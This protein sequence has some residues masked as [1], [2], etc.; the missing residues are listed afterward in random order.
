MFHHIRGVDQSTGAERE[1]SVHAPTEAEAWVLA[2][3]HGIIPR[4]SYVPP[5][6]SS[7][8]DGSSVE[9]RV[10]EGISVLIGSLLVA[11]GLMGIF[12]S[13]AMDTSINIGDRTTPAKVENLGMLHRQSNY[14]NLSIAATAIGVFLVVPRR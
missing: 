11:G 13:L 6:R 8:S 12:G 9:D 10:S 2:G 14:L 7:A 1:L 5:A 4:E 3:K